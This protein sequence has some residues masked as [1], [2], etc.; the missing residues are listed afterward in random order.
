MHVAQLIIEDFSRGQSID[1][2][3]GGI[4]GQSIT[5]EQT[6]PR[7]HFGTWKHAVYYG[8]ENVY[9]GYSLACK[10]IAKTYSRYGLVYQNR[11]QT[12]PYVKGTIT[13]LVMSQ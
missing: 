2:Q 11:G 13:L 7:V 3:R 12:V 6:L 1:S 8:I 5:T 4:T 9:L 10:I